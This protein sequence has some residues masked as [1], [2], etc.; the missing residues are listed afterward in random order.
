M[1]YDYNGFVNALASNIVIATTNADFVLQL[2]HFISQAELRI[3]RD[4]DLLSTVFRDTGAALFL[5]QR[6]V[7]LPQTYGR[8]V[9]V[10]GVNVL[11]SGLRS[12]ALIPVSREFIDAL[13]PS[14]VAPLTTSLPRVFCRD[15]DTTILIAPT[16]GATSN[17]TGLEIV[18]TVRPLTLSATNTTTFISQYLPDLF[19]AAAMVLAAGWM[20]NFG[21]QSDDPKQAL[22][23][24]A[25]YAGLLPE[26][27]TEE[28]RKRFMS[29]SW[30]A[31]SAPSSQPERV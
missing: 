29:G 21:A 31:K 24:D 23:W 1:A 10:E 12:N 4:L 11:V 25:V 30:T 18:G 5:G 3:Y 15:T 27:K 2:P 20:K 7:T 28:N 22:S 16:Y 17:V 13:H 26:A 14:E 8:F 19:M 9:V 6:T